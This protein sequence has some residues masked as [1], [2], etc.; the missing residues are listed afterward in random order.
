MSTAP[1]GWEA[2]NEGFQVTYKD[3]YTS[4]CPKE[5]FEESNL[6]LHSGD[7]TISH[8]DVTNF[9]ESTEVKTF[10][11]KTTVVCAT[12]VNGFKIVE[13]SSCVD[14]KN[15]DPEIGIEICEE[16]IRNKV[17]ELLGFLLQSAVN[18]FNEAD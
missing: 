16:R 7:N 18:G 17:W 13:A 6:T 1:K 5:A 12:L 2:D 14:P 9:I 8:I 4:W 10:G 15:Y 11:D 3:G